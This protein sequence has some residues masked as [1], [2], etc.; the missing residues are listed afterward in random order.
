[1]IPGSIQLIHAFEDHEHEHAATLELEQHFHVDET[2]C[3]LCDMQLDFVAFTVSPFTFEITR[4]S[5]TTEVQTSYSYY[6][7]D[8]WISYSERGPPAL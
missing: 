8:P 1:M 5:V 3:I 2:D 7:N 4:N 6:Q